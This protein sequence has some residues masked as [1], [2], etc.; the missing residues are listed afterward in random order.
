[1]KILFVSYYNPSFINTSVYRAKALRELGHQIITFQ[2]RQFFLPGRIRQKIHFLHNWDLKRLNKS[3]LNIAIHQKP[4]LCLVIG[5]YPILSE[6]LSQIKKLGVKLILWT[7]DVPINFENITRTAPLYDYI[8]CAGTEALEIFTDIGLNRIKWL[9][10]ACDPDYHRP[11]LLTD[12]E[13]KS[14]ANDIVFVGSFYPNRWKIL[15]ELKEFDLAILGPGWNKAIAPAHEK[16]YI[17]DVKL[18]Y[19]EWVKIYN[20]AKIVLVIHYD[21][22]KTLSY[23]ASPKVYE[24]LA[25][26]TLVLV[27]QQRDIFSLFKDREHLVTFDNI[28]DLKEQIRYYLDN[29]YERNRI[30]TQGYTEVLEKHTYVHRISELLS[31]VHTSTI[32]MTRK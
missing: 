4:D 7:T 28:M 23:Q 3:L 2:D 15:K 27:D 9:P 18:N 6:T 30:A 24:A 21:D 19:S 10:F 31:I 26:K 14:Y 8:F 17:R 32:D 25:C 29:T 5:G 11:L 22:G 12:V 13:E 1:M 20:A 16:Q